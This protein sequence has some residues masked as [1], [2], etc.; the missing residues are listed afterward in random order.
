MTGG[1]LLAA[2]LAI[3]SPEVDSGLGRVADH[4]ADGARIDW[5]VDFA[6]FWIILLFAIMAAWMF[7][8]IALHREKRHEAVYETG[9]SKRG[10]MLAI[11]IASFVFFVIDGALFAKS[12]IDMG[13]VFWNFERADAEAGVVRI[14][15]NA[16]Q[17]VWDVRYA[18]PDGR[19]NTQD[20]VIK[21]NDVRVALDR[22]V[23]IQIGAVDV[24]HSL[25]IPH[26][27][28][29][30]DAMPGT[31]T[32]AWFTPKRTGRFEIACAQHCGV[33]HYKMR[34]LLTVMEPDEFDRWLEI[35]SRDAIQVY[36]EKDTEAHW[37]WAWEVR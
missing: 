34:G 22:P 31:I 28:V 16:R 27:R 21:T 8:A 13:E 15:M 29:K 4:S 24:V 1:A 35:E 10:W 5:L 18:G 14:E 37:G 33:N 6:N 32:Q 26:F 9:D 17:W 11:G 3:A 20:D 25:Y 7:A 12:S 23:L 30:Q 2:G 36:V 19:F